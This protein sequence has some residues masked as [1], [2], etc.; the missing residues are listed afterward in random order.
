MVAWEGH[1]LGAE[2]L[3][4]GDGGTAHHLT[5]RLRAG[6]HHDLGRCGPKRVEV[7]L[8]MG[9][10]DHVLA[11]HWIRARAVVIGGHTEHRRVRRGPTRDLCSVWS[12]MATDDDE[13][14]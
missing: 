2:P 14:R 9:A 11:E 3:C 1:R 10:G 6:G 7:G 4:D 8:V 13:V 5:L 12:L